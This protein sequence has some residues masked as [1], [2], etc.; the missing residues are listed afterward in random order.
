MKHITALGGDRRMAEAARILR[1]RGFCVSLCAT[2]EKVD[3]LSWKE[4]LEGSEKGDLLLLPVPFSRDGKTV[5]CAPQISLDAVYGA[6]AS[7]PFV[8]GGGIP[9]SLFAR[10]REGGDAFDLLSDSLFVLEN[11]YLTADAA[12]GMLLLETERAPRDTRALILGYG[13]IAAALCNR[14]HALGFRVSVCARNTEKRAEALYAGAEE[15]FD[16]CELPKALWGKDVLINTA[17]AA[18]L[19]KEWLESAK[20]LRILELASGE[21]F[22]YAMPEGVSLLRA[23]GLPGKVYPVSAGALIADAACRFLTQKTRT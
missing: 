17:P 1:E 18:L 21:N 4:S 7:F 11:A 8:C 12:L 10:A 3:G 15:A 2:M 14:M 19:Q 6:C 16:V 22:P 20:G 23:P 13:R 5:F 9:A